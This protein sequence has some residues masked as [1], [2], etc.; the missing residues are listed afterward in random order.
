MRF[1]VVISQILMTKLRRHH[2]GNQGKCSREPK[3]PW[4]VQLAATFVV[5]IASCNNP[6]AVGEA[7]GGNSGSR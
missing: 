3:L 5:A 4:S 6:S 7:S 1:A 2:A